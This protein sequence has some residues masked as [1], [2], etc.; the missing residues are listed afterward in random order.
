MSLLT[1]FLLISFHI[2][3]HI[4]RIQITIFVAL[5]ILPYCPIGKWLSRIYLSYFVCLIFLIVLS[6][7]RNALK[8]CLFNPPIYSCTYI[9]W[10]FVG[11]SFTLSLLLAS[12]KCMQICCVLMI[13]IMFLSLSSTSFLASG[14][15][16]PCLQVMYFPVTWSDFLIYWQLY[17]NFNPFFFHMSSVAWYSCILYARTSFFWATT[18]L[19]ASH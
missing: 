7:D 15:A 9:A 19:D 1:S 14:T 13:H 18:F 10:F 11:F 12:E 17:Q 3:R 6:S 5:N 2:N 8:I 4:N 16:M